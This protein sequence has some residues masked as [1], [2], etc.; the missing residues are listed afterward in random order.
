[1]HLPKNWQQI[2]PRYW[3]WRNKTKNICTIINYRLLM[4][5][6]YIIVEI[7]VYIGITQLNNVSLWVNFM[8]NLILSTI[9]AHIFY[10]CTIIIPAEK[11][12]KIAYEIIT[13]KLNEHLQLFLNCMYSMLNKNTILKIHEN[14]AKNKADSYNISWD[15]VHLVTEQL[16]DNLTWGKDYLTCNW[17][18]IIARAQDRCSYLVDGYNNPMI[19]IKTANHES[20]SLII[21]NSSQQIKCNINNLL[22]KYGL[23]IDFDYIQLLEKILDNNLMFYLDSF[24]ELNNSDRATYVSGCFKDILELY[25]KNQQLKDKYQRSSDK[26]SNILCKLPI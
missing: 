23:W 13:R 12:K 6:M 21:H 10:I 15:S 9:A 5:I 4:Q 11:N 22:L 25:E 8:Q 16:L 14:L 26:I 7:L 3:K 2:M 19:N 20:H 1:M 18:I 24:Y 17:K